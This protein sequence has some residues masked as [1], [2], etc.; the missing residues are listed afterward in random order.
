MDVICFNRYNAWYKE[1]GQLE[2]IQLGVET[3]A[4]N[5]RDKHLKPVIISEYGA[6]TY[7]GLHIVR[8]LLFHI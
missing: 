2:S 4:Q 5:W 1:P 6:D 7:E 8:Y 3:E